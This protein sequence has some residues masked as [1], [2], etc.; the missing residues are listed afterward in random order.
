[1]TTNSEITKGE[2]ILKLTRTLLSYDQPKH[3]LSNF[4]DMYV[5]WNQSDHADC[6][7]DRNSKSGTF[8]CI[9]DF[10]GGLNQIK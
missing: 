10:L 3:L 8:L 2:Q 6:Q 5:A 1:M 4:T 7:S 9:L